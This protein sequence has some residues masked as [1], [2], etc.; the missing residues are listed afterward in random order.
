MSIVTEIVTFE[1]L[2][3]V[4]FEEFVQTVDMLECEFHSQQPGFIDTELLYD[5][6]QKTWTMIQHW[7]SMDELKKASKKMFEESVTEAF[8]KALNTKCI[9]IRTYPQLQVWR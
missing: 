2:E 3:D 1:T 7:E 8:R 9:R 5:S 6:K 4:S